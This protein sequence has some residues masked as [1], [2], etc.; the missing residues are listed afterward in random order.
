MKKLFY[1]SKNLLINPASEFKLISESVPDIWTINKSFV[2]P[3]ALIIAGFSLIGSAFSNISS[4]INTF[5]YIGVNAVIL[6]LLV[7]THSYISGKTIVLLGQNIKQTENPENYYALAIYS[8]LPFYLML[9][10]IKL[11]PSL[12]FLMFIGLYSGLLF[13]TGSGSLSKI[14]SEK[15]LQFTLLSILIMVISF[16]IFSELYT[17]LYS[18]IVE[19]FSTFAGR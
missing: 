7:L 12:V 18:E 5:V 4:P 15:S 14:P 13:Y 1:R 16:V 17:I 19:Q 10:I 3:L 2:I 6:F 11:F 8:Q 9:A